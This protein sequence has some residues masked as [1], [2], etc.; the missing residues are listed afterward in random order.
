MPLVAL[1]DSWAFCMP[2]KTA[3]QSL[4]AMTEGIAEVK[5]DWHGT[6]YEGK[7]KRYM[8]VR[9]PY[10][11]LASLY[12][13]SQKEMSYPLAGPPDVNGWLERFFAAHEQ[14]KDKEWTP[15]QSEKAS[16]F[17][18]EKV[19]RVEDGLILIL[20]ALGLPAQAEAWRNRTA[21]KYH[22]RLPFNA[23]FRS[24]R[25]D[26]RALVDEWCLPDMEAWY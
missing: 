21:A 15:T 24:A 8:V 26:L 14:G 25:P 7:G 11:R 20:R 3:S 1:D 23:T 10:E 18:P 12:W 13:Y 9:E 5:G 2:K 16:A 4:V 17:G 22:H 6:D 19:F